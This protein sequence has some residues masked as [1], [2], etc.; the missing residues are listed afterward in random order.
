MTT[1]LDALAGS[2]T[3]QRGEQVVN[4]ASEAVDR[5]AA[6][7]NGPRVALRFVGG[8]WDV[9]DISYIELAE[10]SSWFASVL[11]SLGMHKGDRVFVL[12]GRI[13]ELYISVLGALKVGAVV[14]T[15]FAAF[16]P[17]PI[18]QRLRLGGGRVLV[19]TPELCDCQAGRHGS[20]RS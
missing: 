8:A 14:C 9:R 4:I 7:V 1:D 18:T 13:P 12:T 20:R 6:G 10:L 19:T 2:S 11:R 16:G 5:H 3:D 17:E 15:L